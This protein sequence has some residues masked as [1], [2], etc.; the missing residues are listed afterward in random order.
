MK[1]TKLNKKQCI[2]LMLLGVGFLAISYKDIA[3]SIVK[4]IY[5]LEQIYNA[6]NVSKYLKVH[7]LLYEKETDINDQI[8]ALIEAQKLPL[9]KKQSP[10]LSSFKKPE[11]KGGNYEYKY[12]KYK[13]K[14]LLLKQTN[15]L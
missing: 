13:Q 9:H 5:I 6:V 7:I 12:K 15:T 3:E 2:H 14:Y 4:A 11:S 8:K 1:G 10:K